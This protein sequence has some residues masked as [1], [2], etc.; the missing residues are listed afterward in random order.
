MSFDWP[1]L[2]LQKLGDKQGSV[3]QQILTRNVV[4]GRYREQ[5]YLQLNRV[6][7]SQAL[8]RNGNRYFRTF[9]NTKVRKYFVQDYFRTRVQ[10]T[11]YSAALLRTFESTKVLSYLRSYVQY[12]MKVQQTRRQTLAHY[13]LP[14]K[15]TSYLR[16]QL[17]RK[18]L[19]TFVASQLASQSTKLGSYYLSTEVRRANTCTVR[20]CRDSSTCFAL[21]GQ[22]S[23][24]VLVYLHILIAKYEG[25]FESPSKVRR[26]LASQR[27]PYVVRCTEVLSKYFRKYESTTLLCTVILSYFR[28]TF[29]RKQ[30]GST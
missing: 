2:F 7:S 17:V 22:S 19:R 26:Q 25:T 15:V 13:Y 28:S 4:H 9:I 11:T 8:R 27:Q 3:V 5:S 12:D 23:V 18:Y 21:T 16:R 1:S 29:V 20:R 24:T 6:L 10:M 30:Y 14:T